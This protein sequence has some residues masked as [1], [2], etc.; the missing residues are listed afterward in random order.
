MYDNK[1]DVNNPVE[2]KLQVNQTSAE[3]NDLSMDFLSN[4]FKFR[5]NGGNF[6]GSYAYIYMAWA[7]SPLVI[8]QGQSFPVTAR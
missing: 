1:R 8:N 4:G 2:D 6:N 5:Q 7:E 3:S